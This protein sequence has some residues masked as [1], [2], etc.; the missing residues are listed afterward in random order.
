VKAIR[1]RGVV[2]A[3]G[4]VERVLPRPGWELPGVLTAGGMQ[5][6]L[7]ETGEIPDGSVLIAGSG[8]LPLVLAAQL[9]AAGRLPVAVLERGQ[10]IGT[11][12]RHPLLAARAM[13]SWPHLIEGAAA[14]ARLVRFGVP[15]HGGW[16][17]R[18]VRQAGE[19]LE[20]H[21]TDAAGRERLYHVRHLVLHDGLRPNVT[22]L[23]ATEAAGVPVLRAGDCR[24]VLGADAAVLDGARAG[25]LLVRR[26]ADPAVPEGP[27]PAGLGAARRL[28]DAF[29]ALC[30]FTAPPIPPE[31][32]LCRCEGRDRVT[33]DALGTDP[34]ART[35]RLIGRFGMG[36]CQGRFCADTVSEFGGFAPGALAGT[37]PRWPLRP[38]SVAALAALDVTDSD[39]PGVGQD[40]ANG[41]SC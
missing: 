27:L 4:A 18:S 41:Q 10:P 32:V 36:L 34:G 37:A 40:A 7:K 17:V 23:P 5:L 21:A 31:T 19:G 3:V 6:G 12:L 28:Q 38:V 22:G 13:A 25:E 1:P 30:A 16:A 29:T 26:I 35:V 24:D 14:M 9:V 8:P 33:L 15:W 39:E 2:F 20:V 11:G